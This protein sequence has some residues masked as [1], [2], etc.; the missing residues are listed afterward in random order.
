M[1]FTNDKARQA[2][3]QFWTVPFS[4]GK[5]RMF[6]AIAGAIKLK[7]QAIKDVI[8]VFP[9]EALKNQDKVAWDQLKQLYGTSLTL[10]TVVG[11]NKVRGL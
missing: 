7:K 3:K 9:T 1:C 8:V 5:S 10:H 4:K 6:V 2:K 11:I